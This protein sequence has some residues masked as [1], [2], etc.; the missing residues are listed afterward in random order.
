MYITNIEL[1]ARSVLW[2][3]NSKGSEHRMCIEKINGRGHLG[4]ISE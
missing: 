2:A 3:R 1:Y 4:E